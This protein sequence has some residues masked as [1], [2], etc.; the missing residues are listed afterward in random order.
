MPRMD[1]SY[2]RPRTATA[3]QPRLLPDRGRPDPHTAST[4]SPPWRGSRPGKPPLRRPAPTCSSPDA[5]IRTAKNRS[6][7]FDLFRLIS[8]PVGHQTRP[9]TNLLQQM[10]HLYGIP[11]KTPF[12]VGSKGICALLTFLSMQVASAQTPADPKPLETF[13]NC[14]LITNPANDGDSFHVQCEEREFI[15]RLYFVDAPEGD[16]TLSGRIS[17]QA[18]YFGVSPDE[19]ADLAREATKFTGEQLSQPFTVRTRFQDALGQSKLPRYYALVEVN[20]Q[21]L[22]YLLV[23]NGLARIHGAQPQ[24]LNDGDLL[25]YVRALRAAEGEAKQEGRG[26][27]SR[28]ILGVEPYSSAS[29]PTAPIPQTQITNVVVKHG[30]ALSLGEYGGGSK[31]VVIHSGS[32]SAVAFSILD[33]DSPVTVYQRD[34]AGNVVSSREVAAVT[35]TS[36]SLKIGES[37]KLP[38]QFSKGYL[39]FHTGS[40][41]VYYNIKLSSANH[42]N[43]AIS[44]APL[45]RE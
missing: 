42:S 12:A 40:V 4:N 41:W 38:G 39:L 8:Q 23:R 19:I 25:T 1:L 18:Q 10:H 13:E 17:E 24:F 6:P 3:I 28:S 15:L 44:N 31:S 45:P 14:K 32:I 43:L 33:D 26:A 29:P 5:Y 2:E 27:W 37:C 22:D 21:S 36:K 9:P 11:V 35:R 7:A 16:G 30:E 34:A 20:G